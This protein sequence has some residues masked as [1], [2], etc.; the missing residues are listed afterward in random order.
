MI[1]LLSERLHDLRIGK[2]LS[3]KQVALM[4]G[5]NPSTI[6]T[7]ENAERLPSYPALIKLAKI[8]GVSVD[9]LLGIEETYA[10][11]LLKNLSKEE[12][13]ILMEIAEILSSHLGK[14]TGE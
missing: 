5:V 12:R 1:K 9:Y 14:Y 3:Q 10:A 11:D 2:K 8:Y 13:E 6:S 4:I 7:Y